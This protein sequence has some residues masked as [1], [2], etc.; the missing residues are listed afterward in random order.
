MKCFK[1]AKAE[2]VELIVL[3]PDCIR[4]IRP[5]GNSRVVTVGVSPEVYHNGANREAVM[6]HRSMSTE[7]ARWL[8]NV[9]SS[10]PPL[11]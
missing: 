3:F 9:P 11:G 6:Q 7:A 1:E 8:R 5:E 4:S 2:E 10:R